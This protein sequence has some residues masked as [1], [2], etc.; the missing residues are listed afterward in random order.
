MAYIRKTK[1]EWQVQGD[2]GN[3]WEPILTAENL[4]DAREQKRCY[5]EN[6]PDVVHRIKLVRVKKN[7]E[8]N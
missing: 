1:D 7:M 8:K 6:E 2:Y 5:D 4:D 3:G